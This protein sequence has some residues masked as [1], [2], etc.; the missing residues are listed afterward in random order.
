MDRLL[1]IIK[2]VINQIFWGLNSKYVQFLRINWVKDTLMSSLK[3]MALSVWPHW[4]S[5][6]GTQLIKPFWWQLTLCPALLG[7]MVLAAWLWN[8]CQVIS[9]SLKLFAMPCLSG[10]GARDHKGESC[11]NNTYPR[12][13]TRC[14][15]CAL[16]CPSLPL[17]LRGDRTGPQREL[18]PQMSALH[19]GEPHH[20]T[21]QVDI[22]HLRA[23]GNKCYN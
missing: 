8:F 5:E 10:V 11:S 21:P 3:M 16:R 22:W 20:T 13:Q 7:W 17:Q 1:W 12:S 23:P 9:D 15:S 2:V 14:Q 19:N 6:A 4:G 18:H